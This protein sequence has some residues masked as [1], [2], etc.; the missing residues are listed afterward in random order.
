M[1]HIHVAL[2]VPDDLES[3]GLQ[4]I[5]AASADMTV[6]CHRVIPDSTDWAQGKACAQ[7]RVDVAVM[8]LPLRWL[9]RMVPVWRRHYP[10]VPLV[11]ILK[12]PWHWSHIVRLLQD[13]VTG[14][15]SAGTAS[16]ILSM[17]RLAAYHTGGVDGD[18]V[19]QMLAAFQGTSTEY[20]LTPQDFR[21]WEGIAHGLSNPQIATSCDLSLAQVKHSVHRIFQYLKVH[22]RY[23]AI[24]WYG[25][26]DLTSA[27][28]IDNSAKYPA[29]IR[30]HEPARH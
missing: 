6:C 2:W 4:Q 12:E 18:M 19:Q 17:I 26:T 7:Q 13:G 8:L 21:I 11:A 5:I 22:S 29:I 16:A 24:A 30:A 14:L 28:E 23:Q 1:D 15:T 25:G 3:E 27:P 10:Q 9:D 20:H